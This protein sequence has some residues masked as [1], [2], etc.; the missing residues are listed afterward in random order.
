[1]L[2]PG[3]CLVCRQPL[4]RIGRL[5]V[6]GEC[7]SGLKSYHGP[8][9]AEC[10]RP[11]PSSVPLLTD[12]PLCGLCR[13]GVFHFERARYF[14]LYEGSLRQM[15]LLLKFGRQEQLGYRLGR[16][17]GDAYR[18]HEEVQQCR[19]V[20]PVPLH[21]ARKRERGFNQ[22]EALAAGVARSLGLSLNSGIL[23]RIRPT[24][25]Q[26]GLSYGAR[27]RNVQ[28]AFEVRG[29]SLRGQPVLLV[30]DVMTTGATAHACAMRLKQAGAEKVLVLTLARAEPL[31]WER[32][33][34]LAGSAPSPTDEG[35]RTPLE[36]RE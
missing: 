27:R 32:D 26:T 25:P 8:A 9:C 6:C 20:V 16:L 29:R 36:V 21:R 5:P 15:V 14:G 18:F 3:A 35:G 2:F 12:T 13:Q 22:A 30:D 7:W 34:A 19:L 28:G 24:P 11:F 23:H 1:M 33:A 10:G 17:L 4:V 31:V